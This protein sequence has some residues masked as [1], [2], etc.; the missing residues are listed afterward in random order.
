MALEH[1]RGR[2]A[3]VRLWF[4]CGALTGLL[5]VAAAALTAHIPERMLAPGGREALRSAV[6]IIG[7]H[8][9]ALLA[10]ALWLD[11]MGLGQGGRPRLIHLAAACFVIGTV[12]FCAGVAVPAFGGPHLGRVAPTGGS[13]LMIGW[14]LLAA[15][16]IPGR[17]GR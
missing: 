15:S 12:C 14:A 8:A 17:F 7:W 9:G 13:L 5:A 10:A 4:A 3:T 2:E 1:T 11:Q 6:Q 16:A